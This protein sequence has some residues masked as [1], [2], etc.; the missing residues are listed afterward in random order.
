LNLTN[1]GLGI[2]PSVLLDIFS[3]KERIAQLDESTNLGV[4]Y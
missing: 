2:L 3:L 4:K 1:E